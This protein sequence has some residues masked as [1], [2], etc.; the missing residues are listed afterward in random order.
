MSSRLRSRHA[1]I[2]GRAALVMALAALMTTV[3]SC[4]STNSP[5]AAGAAGGAKDP[6]IAVALIA[7]VGLLED[8]VAA[9]EAELAK[10][11]YHPHYENYNA[12]G[13]ISNVSTIV[14]QIA[15]QH[16]DL[17][18]AV[19]T[20]LNVAVMQELP[21]TPQVFGVMSDPVGAKL[22]H[23]LTQPGGYAT[24]T[25]GAVPASLTFDILTAAIPNL[26]HVGL[27]GNLAE[28][29]TTSD[30]AHLSAEA[31]KRGIEFTVRPVTSTEDV[32]SAIRSFSGIQALIIPGDNT[33]VSAI[34]TV[35]QTADA[36]HIPTFD[37]YGASLAEQGITV[38]FGPD[39]NVLGT[40]AAEQ[41]A[42]IL[43]GA[44]PADIPVVGLG[45]PGIPNLVY[46]N[47]ASAAKVDLT[48]TPALRKLVAKT[49][50]G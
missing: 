40:A 33:V 19:G 36:Q 10:L 20:P 11:G 18:Y 15:Q 31:R 38:A 25:S 45:S 49:I 30:I 43:G 29:N 34:A 39:Y 35:A 41:A 21:K 5:G 50:G 2:R 47:S 28:T 13:Q 3:S 4:S 22:A 7:P 17:V 46:L 44:S 14:E 27:I 6:T 24:G 42:K 8:N 9:F 1:G 12:Q 23:S 16:P 26:K 48:V 32:A 37:P